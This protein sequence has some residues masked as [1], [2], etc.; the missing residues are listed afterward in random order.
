[1]GGVLWLWWWRRCQWLRSWIDARSFGA[2]T[3]EGN[4][5]WYGMAMLDTGSGDD[6]VYVRVL[7][8]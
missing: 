2:K 6:A 8:A 3:A 5:A 1:V 4:R 7:A